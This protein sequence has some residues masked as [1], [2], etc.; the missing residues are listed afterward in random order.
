MAIICSL[1]IFSSQAYSYGEY[2]SSFEGEWE[3][4]ISER[5]EGVLVGLELYVRGNGLRGEFKILSDVEGDVKKGMS[6]YIEDVKVRGDNLSFIV[7]LFAGEEDDNL[8]F[9]LRLGW[10][11]LSG[12]MR[13][14]YRG[15][16][17]I[18]VTFNKVRRRGLW[19]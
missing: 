4:E 18:P 10:S 13:E 12:T 7:P 6:F 9:E 14:M 5:D 17:I 2:Y 11:G 16:K 1:G 19:Y 3:A 15:S 8:F